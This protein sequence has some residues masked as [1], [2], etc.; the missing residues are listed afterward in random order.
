[1]AICNFK[2]WRQKKFLG[3]A[4]FFKRYHNKKF[5]KI[6]H[7]KHFPPQVQQLLYF[8]NKYSPQLIF[9]RKCKLLDTVIACFPFFPFL[10]II[11]VRYQLRWNSQ[12][13]SAILPLNS[14]HWNLLC[15]AQWASNIL[16]NFSALAKSAFQS[17]KFTGKVRKSSKPQE[18]FA[19]GA[20]LLRI[21]KHLKGGVSV[22]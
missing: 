16:L 2:Y 6:P 11:D 20:F 21:S 19:K 14:I 1:M 9:A 13:L 17:K 10:A 7:Q 15:I 8:F 4:P 18:L 5:Q 22:S 12:S 3:D